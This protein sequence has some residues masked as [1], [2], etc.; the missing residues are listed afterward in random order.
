MCHELVDLDRQTL[1]SYKGDYDFYIQEKALRQEQLSKEFANQQAYIKQQERF[2]ERFKAKASKA[3]QAKSIQKKL[4]KL[5]R[6]ESPEESVKAMNLKFTLDRPSG[7]T[8]L[9]VKNLSKSYGTIKILEEANTLIDRG[10]KIGL[11]GANGVG[12]TTLLHMIAELVD[13][14]GELTLGHHVDWTLYSQHQIESLHMESEIL[15]ELQ[16]H[17]AQLTENDARSIL[18]CFLFSGDDVYKKVKVLSGGEKSRVAL[19]KILTSKA[20]FLLLDEPTN[21]LDMISKDILIQA[22]DQYEGS[23]IMVSHD[24][25]FLSKTT[26]K[27]WEIKNHKIVEYPGSYNEWERDK[28]EES[29]PET[30]SKQQK[31]TPKKESSNKEAHQAQKELKKLYSKSEKLE[32]KLEELQNAETDMLTQLGDPQVYADAQR[33]AELESKHKSIQEEITRTHESYDEVLAQIIE[34][35]D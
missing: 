9:Q 1:T 12:K 3:T 16:N 24:R 29:K 14:Q 5:E 13:Y 32:K 8:V 15:Q 27:I 10:D 18:G 34:L 4:D 22:L 33:F 25:D 19:A 2:V 28:K 21:H 26:N 23:Y 30:P 7:K 35:E 6:V 11:I 31:A 20:N 17:N